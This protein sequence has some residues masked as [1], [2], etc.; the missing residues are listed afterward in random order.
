MLEHMAYLNFSE[1][2]PFSFL[3]FVSFDVGERHYSPDYGTIRNILCKFRKE[4]K[5]KKYG[6]SRPAFYQLMESNL[7]K[8]SMTVTHT[9]G[10]NVISH[11]DPLYNRLNTLPMGQ[12]SIHDIR[13]RF[14]APHFH[15]AYA[16]NTTY[17]EEN[18]NG[19]IRVPWW[20]INNATI[21]VRIH[22]TNTVSIIL[23]CSQEPFPLDFSGITAFFTT[24]GQIRGRLVGT[25][26]SIYSQ[27]INLIQKCVPSL[28]D[29]IIRMWHFG[30]DSLIEYSGKDVHDTVERAGYVLERIYTKISMENTYEDTNSKNTPTRTPLKRLQIN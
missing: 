8:K 1:G 20:K 9:E 11:N 28:S 21:Q 2:E 24:L 12:R 15:E 29:R 5:I 7:G 26:E 27:D 17:H 18:Y 4:G 10:I 3:N 22:K 19:D 6:K 14:T 25:M 16:M 13:I 23:A 30:R